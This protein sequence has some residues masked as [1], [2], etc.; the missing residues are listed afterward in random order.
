MCSRKAPCSACSVNYTFFVGTI[1]RTPIVRDSIVEVGD[2]D[3]QSVRQFFFIFV[4]R[5]E[6][7]GQCCERDEI[8]TGHTSP[9]PCTEQITWHDN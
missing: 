6:S 8:P 3:L 9:L 1:P 2:R 7:H 5:N 4:W